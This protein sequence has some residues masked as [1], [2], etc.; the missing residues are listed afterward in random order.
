M[1]Y[2]L[3]KI[4]LLIFLYV[5][6]MVVPLIS[7]TTGKIA[8][9]ITDK[10]TGDPLVGA[11]IVIVG[12][13]LGSVADISGE[14]SILQVPPNTYSIQVSSI[15]YGKVVINNV[16]VNIDQTSRINVALDIQS[17]Q[18]G[19]TV[20]MAERKSVKPDVSSGVV[21]VSVKDIS[22]LPVSTDVRDLMGMQAGIN[23]NQIR[24]GGLDQ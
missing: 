12:T 3:K 1:A 19:T 20:I 5:L 2:P 24:G 8:G 11:N 21:D 6:A 4:I 16:V 22:I 23:N 9:V 18:L 10:A 13:S 7:G 14:Y 15:G 17:I